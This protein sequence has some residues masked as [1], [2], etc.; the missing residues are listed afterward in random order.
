M[1]LS[2][3]A[4]TKL[5]LYEIPRPHKNSN[6]FILQIQLLSLPVPLFTF[7][8]IQGLMDLLPTKIVLWAEYKISGM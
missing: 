6:E 4:K 1:T 3:N 8:I 5:G 2:R 7:C